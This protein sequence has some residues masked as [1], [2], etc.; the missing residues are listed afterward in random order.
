MKRI[1]L[2]CLLCLLVEHL[3]AQEWPSQEFIEQFNYKPVVGKIEEDKKTNELTPP[4]YPNGQ[5]GILTL[6]RNETRYPNTRERPKNNGK[7]LLSYIIEK[8]GYVKEIKVLESA[9]KPFDNE[10]IR[11]LKKMERWIPGTVN[12][13]NVRVV[14]THPIRFQ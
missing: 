10:A 8:D 4:L 14:Y 2:V 9:G 11:V 3:L 1:V 7:V 6:V 12:G 13:E 5:Q